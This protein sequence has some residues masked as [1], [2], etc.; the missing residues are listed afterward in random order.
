M[1]GQVFVFGRWE[2]DVDAAL[3]LVA[4]GRPTGRVPMAALAPLVGFMDV[5]F[6][7]A[8]AADLSQPVLLAPFPDADGANMVIDGWHRVARALLLGVPDLPAVRLTEAEGD[9]VRSQRRRR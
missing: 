1:S 2:W 6:D 7:H 9:A 3:E 8:A 4:D 5:D